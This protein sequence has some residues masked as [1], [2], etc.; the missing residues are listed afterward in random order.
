MS[1]NWKIAVS[2]T[3]VA[4]LAY[5]VS[6][7]KR[8]DVAGGATTAPVTTQEPTVAVV[9]PAVAEVEPELITVESE[10]E[11]LYEIN[12]LSVEEAFDA[13]EQQ[14]FKLLEDYKFHLANDTAES[15]FGIFRIRASCRSLNLYTQRELDD[16]M[17]GAKDRERVKFRAVQLMRRVARCREVVAFIGDEEMDDT[18]PMADPLMKSLMKSAEMGHPMGKLIMYKNSD[19][20]EMAVLFTDAYEYSKKFP[21]FKAEVY[22]MALRYV[23]R[24]N[25][26]E[27]SPTYLALFYMSL[28]DGPIFNEVVSP[29]E[30]VGGMNAGMAE[31]Y[32]PLKLDA[33]H[34]RREEISKAMENGDWSWL[35]SEN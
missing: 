3:L 16:W 14:A 22:N 18:D 15:H 8:L 34:Q 17:A 21:Q 29:N 27:H 23:T 32:L 4:A 20:K 26:Y 12:Y 31:D 7:L 19:H 13:T 24:D 35:L 10:P 1:I 28:R 30:V 9:T 11:D 5:L 25:E 2:V 33:I 6:D